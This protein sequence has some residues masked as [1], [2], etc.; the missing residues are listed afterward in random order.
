MT[1][2]LDVDA[3]EASGRRGRK[4]SGGK[5]FMQLDVSRFADDQAVLEPIE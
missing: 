2:L 1:R 3:Q 5:L 4:L